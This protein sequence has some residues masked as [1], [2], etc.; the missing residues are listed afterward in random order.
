MAAGG[1][2]CA[3]CGYPVA[4]S[5]LPGGEVATAFDPCDEL[6]VKLRQATYGEYEVKSELGRG[7]M[8]IV[9]LAHDFRL[10]RKVAIKVMFPGLLYTERGWE[11]FLAEART[12]AKLDHPNVSYVH[13]V[14]DKDRFFYFIM[15]YV[16]GRPLDD[17]LS[18]SGALP[19]AVAQSILVQV[20]RG[21]EYAHRE[22][23]VH[24]DI[25]PANIM[26]DKKGNAIVMDFGIARVEDSTRFT[27]TGAA[28]GTPAYMSPEQCRGDEVTA[29]SDQYSLGVVA[30]ELFSGQPPFNGSSAELQV[31]HIHDEPVDVGQL[32]AD[33]P[34]E[35]TDAVM[36]MLEKDP[37]KRFPSLTQLIAIF[38]AGFDPHAAE[39]AD[40]L[41][42]FVKSGPPRR[43]SLPATPIS[44][45]P[46]VEVAEAQRAAATK[47]VSTPDENTAE[48]ELMPVSGERS[49]VTAAP[50]RRRLALKPPAAVVVVAIVVVAVV[51][52]AV[53]ASVRT[54]SSGPA[55][56]IAPSADSTP[57]SAAVAVVTALGDSVVVGHGPDANVPTKGAL[58]RTVNPGA[59]A[60]FKLALIK[61]S[62]VAV[63]DTVRVRLDAID[64]SGALVTSPQIVWSTSDPRVA[65]FAGP[66]RLVGVH[67]GKATITVTA[68]TTT[69]SLS[70][71][72][73][74]RAAAG[75][76]RK[77]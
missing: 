49:A 23:I 21:L 65:T 7:G 75:V 15:K 58:P 12:A 44:G 53:I 3:A 40:Q 51:V 29:A 74:P 55:A 35:L 26:I 48:T 14:R 56:A 45:V 36:R 43:Q 77:Q 54:R 4:H 18:R 68:G 37:A 2:F 5:T 39:I 32:R 13:S 41:V 71:T 66:G 28:I 6:L 34:P 76:R 27:Q 60:L 1:R 64:D 24:R 67:E 72:V 70:V 61:G 62:K 17:I 8:A 46:A 47:P 63:G 57:T 16:D 30:Y 25:K 22:G 9:Y 52:V 50:T 69:G 73:G 42:A 19:I 59:I 38:S 10:N 20:A 33:L 11:R 31:A